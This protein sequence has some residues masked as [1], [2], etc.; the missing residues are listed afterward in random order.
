MTVVLPYRVFLNFKGKFT[1]WSFGPFFQSYKWRHLCA[2]A[3]LDVYIRTL[4]SYLRRIRGW[5]SPSSLASYTMYS[6]APA[7]HYLRILSYSSQ[8]IWVLGTWD[9]TDTR[10]PSLRTWIAWQRADSGLLISTAPAQSAVRPGFH[11]SVSAVRYLTHAYKIAAAVV[12]CLFVF[13]FSRSWSQCI[14]Q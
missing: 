9:V 2:T 5:I 13:G 8:M 4:P 1:I 10:L 11:K 7:R 3:P 6:L 12:V 14:L